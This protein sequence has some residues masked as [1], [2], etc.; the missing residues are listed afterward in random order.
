MEQKTPKKKIGILGYILIAGGIF[1]VIIF[2]TANTNGTTS[3]ISPSAVAPAPVSAGVEKA[4]PAQNSNTQASGQSSESGTPSL[5][6]K[7]VTGVV[8]TSA[9]NFNQGM[10]IN[11]Q[12]IIFGGDTDAIN[13][14]SGWYCIVNGDKNFV[15]VVSGDTVTVTGEKVAPSIQTLINCRV[16]SLQ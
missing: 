15:S 7:T 8:R 2:F 16:D 5:V 1:Y 6:R 11:Q 14:G 13:D 9:I 12:V 4:T 3:N 10:N